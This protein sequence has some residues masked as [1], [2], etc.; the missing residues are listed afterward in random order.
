MAIAPIEIAMATKDSDLLPDTNAPETPLTQDWDSEE[1]EDEDYYFGAEATLPPGHYGGSILSRIPDPGMQRRTLREL[2]KR[3]RATLSPAFPV[4]MRRILPGALML[5]GYRR[6]ALRSRS[7]KVDDYGRDRVY[8]AAVKPYLDFLYDKW[9]RVEMRGIQNIPK[10]GPAIL[11]SNHT[12]SLPYD[13]TMLM[14][15]LAREPG[16]SPLRP[17]LEDR[18]F[19]RPYLGTMLRRLGAVR[20][21]RDNAVRLLN[22]GGLIAVFPEGHKAALKEPSSHR[23]ERFGRGG[24]IRLA[25][26]T[27][28]PILPVAIVAHPSKV[29]RVVPLE[30]RKIATRI[31]LIPAPLRWSVVIGESVDLSEHLAGEE[32]TNEWHDRVLVA[33]ETHRIR[34]QIREMI[35][36]L[37]EP[38]RS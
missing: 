4:E 25:L 21:C 5:D 20:A 19:Q 2:E 23:L 35:E 33:D 36:A 6:F 7:I 18:V 28:A 32:V 38:S 14:H 30:V 29:D 16:L 10:Q 12:G 11:V 22:E 15:G 37:L 17:L 31:G 13:A 8:C 9:L 24:F 27:G 34:M 26:R 3:V 1:D